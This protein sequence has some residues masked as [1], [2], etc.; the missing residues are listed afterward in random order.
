MNKNKK[1]LP[2]IKDKLKVYETN[3]SLLIHTL[4]DVFPE[5]CLA[6]EEKL[7]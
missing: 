4:L 2:Y 3:T 7:H 5:N 1:S 6:K